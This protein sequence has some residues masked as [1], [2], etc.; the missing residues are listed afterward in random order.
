MAPAKA[1]GVRQARCAPRQVFCEGESEDEERA[2]GIY[3][4]VAFRI[5]SNSNAANRIVMEV[6]PLFPVKK[7][8]FTVRRGFLMK[9]QQNSCNFFPNS[10]LT[11]R[12]VQKMR[13]L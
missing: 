5:K 4:E 6:L 7:G 10:A 1:H 9:F 11:F 8:I 2:A 3:G 12:V 13:G